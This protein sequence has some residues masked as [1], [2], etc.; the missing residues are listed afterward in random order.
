MEFSQGNFLGYDLY[1]IAY[2]KQ[3]FILSWWNWEQVI[4]TFFLEDCSET[5]KWWS[6]LVLLTIYFIYLLRKM[7]RKDGCWRV[8]TYMLSSPCNLSPS[9]S[10]QVIVG[11][12]GE[13]I[14]RKKFPK[15]LK[16]PGIVLQQR[17]AMPWSL[18][19]FFMSIVKSMLKML[20]I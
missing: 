20:S 14:E 1:A 8:Q 9:D 6:G 11:D 4:W 16:C 17:N 19:L 2:S 5:E 7:T 18:H 10:S 13:F 12:A 3:Y 15:Q